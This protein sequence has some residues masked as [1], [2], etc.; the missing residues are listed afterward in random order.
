M[1]SSIKP[2]LLIATLCFAFLS[3]S[4]F[5]QD[6]STDPQGPQI[7]SDYGDTCDIPFLELR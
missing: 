7:T 3:T 2:R 6:L 1:R 4:A 5:A